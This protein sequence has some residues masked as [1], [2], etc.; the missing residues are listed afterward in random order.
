MATETTPTNPD[1][2]L[3]LMQIKKAYKQ[4]VNSWASDWL[5]P[6]APTAWS[7]LV[8]YNWV[9]RK[10]AWGNTFKQNLTFSFNKGHYYMK[11]LETVITRAQGQQAVNYGNRMYVNVCKKHSSMRSHGRNRLWQPYKHNPNSLSNP[12]KNIKTVSLL[13]AMELVFKAFVII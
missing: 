11:S 2:E 12:E 8:N 10:C 7:N 1:C 13:K 4:T 6:R 5:R 3:T 9:V